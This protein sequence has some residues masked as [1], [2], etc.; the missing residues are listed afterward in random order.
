MAAIS[1][2]GSMMKAQLAAYRRTLQASFGG[3]SSLDQVTTD[4]L[5][6]LE[7]PD[8][9]LVWGVALG[10]RRDIE[11]LLARTAKLLASGGGSATMYAPAWYAA[12]APSG[13]AAASGAGGG[14]ASSLGGPGAL[15][16]SVED[17]AAM[18][19]GIEAI[20]S[21]RASQTR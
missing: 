1:R 8:Q 9:T 2:E 12:G 21:E 11:A 13:A 6:W 19:A 5:P 15:P 14:A 18:F 16:A 3:A 10:L 4:R 7:T 20:G 17:A